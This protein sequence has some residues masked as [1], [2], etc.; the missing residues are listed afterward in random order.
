[1]FFFFLSL[2]SEFGYFTS[3]TDSNITWSGRF[4]E[5]QGSSGSMVGSNLSKFKV[6]VGK[7]GLKKPS[8]L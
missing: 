7:N 6:K 5:Y 4:A 8:V 1:M 2:A 3:P